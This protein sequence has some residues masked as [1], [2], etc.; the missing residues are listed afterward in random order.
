MSARLILIAA[1]CLAAAS[2][3]PAPASGASREFGVVRP[4][5]AADSSRD[6]ALRPDSGVWR[7]FGPDGPVTYAIVRDDNLRSIIVRFHG[8]AA[9]SKQGSTVRRDQAAEV[10]RVT[11]RFEND[12]ARL[13]AATAGTAIAP[14]IAIRQR[15]SR[16]LSG[17]AVQVPA[18]LESQL[19][20]LPYVQSVSPDVEVRAS[21]FSS[22][23]LIRADRVWGEFGFTGAGVRVG[24]I[25]TGVDYHHPWLGGG[26]GPGFRVAGGWDFFND[27]ADPMDDEGHGTHVAGIVAAD[28]SGLRGVAPRAT[29]YAYKVLG[30]GGFGPMSNIIAALERSADPDG[31][32]ATD[33]ALDVVNL[34]LGSSFGSADDPGAV[35]IDALS[36]LGTVCV[37]AA[38]NSGVP[39]SIST[40]ASA[41]AAISVAASDDNDQIAGFSSRGPVQGTFDLKPEL[42]APGV[43]ILSLAPGGGTATRSGTSMAAPHVA[44]VAAL[45]IEQHQDWTVEDVRAALV[46]TARPNAADSFAAG[47]G[48]LDAYAAASARWLVTPSKLSF[49]RMRPALSHWTRAETLSVRSW[50]A[51]PL[52]LHFAL[53]RRAL[54]DGVAIAVEPET[55]EIAAGG[56]ATAIV[57]LVASPNALAAPNAV[58][59][60]WS[61]TLVAS[62]AD[63]QTRRVP[64]GVHECVE[65][66]SEDSE[67]IERLLIHDRKGRQFERLPGFDALFVPAGRYDLVAFGNPAAASGEMAIA[68]HEG[69]DLTD[70]RTVSLS[71]AEATERITFE[72]LAPDGTPLAADR[73]D[74]ELVMVDSHVLLATYGGFGVQSFR[75][76][77]GTSGYRLEY[78]RRRGAQ[79]RRSF[80]V[81]G[82]VAAPFATRIESNRSDAFRRLS[83]TFPSFA[84]LTGRLAFDL[85]PDR[86]HGGY[87][88]FAALDSIAEAGTDGTTFEC[89]YVPPATPRH[90]YLGQRTDLIDLNAGPLVRRTLLS[91]PTLDFGAG[92]GVGIHPLSLFERPSFVLRGEALR[93]GALAPVFRGRFNNSPGQV[94]L[95][96]SLGFSGGPFT[97]MTGSTLLPPA[98]SWRLTSDS[99]PIASGILPAGGGA[100]DPRGPFVPIAIPGPFQ[101]EIEHHDW[102][103]RGRPGALDVRARFDTR[104][105][106]PDP[107][108]LTSFAVLADGEPA[109]SIDLGSAATPEVRFELRDDSHARATLEWRELGAIGWQP[110]GAVADSGLASIALPR[111]LAGAI[112]LRLVTR[113]GWGNELEIVTSPAF[114]ARP[115]LDAEA[116]GHVA[117]LDVGRVELRWDLALPDGARLGVERRAE[118][119]AWRRVGFASTVSP[120]SVGYHDDSVTPGRIYRYRLL[121]QHP[122]RTEIEIAVPIDR[123]SL[124]LAVGPNPTAGPFVAHLR[125]P[126][127]GAAELQVLDIAGRRVFERRFD[128]LSAGPTALELEWPRGT[129]PGL[130]FVRV[131][132]AGQDRI[133]RIT[134]LR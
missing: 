9:F 130:Y 8:P 118:G 122:E 120:T 48:R 30:S 99:E 70:D 109:D 94:A 3:R 117:V 33:D 91:T 6:Q 103:L 82:A 92:D 31:D 93:F 25:D 89:W 55:L 100:F 97:D 121:V 131:R 46:E 67:V 77:P 133:A 11:A 32:P 79:T 42:C 87:F 66:A 84:G 106:D 53:E 110:L 81:P 119:E 37:V 128:A 127:A 40:P 59:F 68:L 126:T 28:G 129:R 86:Q 63:G 51:A 116:R 13:A 104:R 124:E 50:S 56:T 35:A 60:G 23:P 61:G 96:S 17:V 74:F 36:A 38:G 5:L 19:K 43:E 26:F 101:F 62:A 98:A 88:G 80:A 34:S 114:V 45:L 24:I 123:P 71:F 57:R 20:A 102:T 54:P 85:V 22:V 12:L 83:Q 14:G 47:A 7:I 41:R 52:R 58:P 2:S 105:L 108:L 107:P 113:D 95:F 115:A 111:S 65:F 29:L 72:N 78:V 21:L 64:F 125:L 39:F 1:L 15:F 44:G 27:D 76:S 112:E 16:L 73:T 75:V 10:D 90:L 134:H 18:A 49:G 132:W 4:G 69:L